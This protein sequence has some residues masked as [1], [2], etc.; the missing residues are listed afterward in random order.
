MTWKRSVCQST[1]A[2]LFELD[3]GSSSVCASVEW[4]ASCLCFRAAPETKRGRESCGV[5]RGRCRALLRK[6]DKRDTRQEGEVRWSFPTAVYDIKF[7]LYVYIKS[8]IVITHKRVREATLQYCCL[9]VLRSHFSM[10]EEFGRAFFISLSAAPLG[11]RLTPN[12]KGRL[13][14]SMVV[15]YRY[16]W[17][18]LCTP[19]CCFMVW[20]VLYRSN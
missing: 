6:K 12:L 16:S 9:I 3:E 10:W 19:Q 8:Y 2:T 1:R 17:S 15:D 20:L 11:R 14:Q 5:L 7:G 13:V 4:S 18:G